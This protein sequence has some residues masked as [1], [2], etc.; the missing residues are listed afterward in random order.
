MLSQITYTDAAEIPMAMQST[1]D[2]RHDAPVRPADEREE[3]LAMIAK[4]IMARWDV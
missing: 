1:S 2:F 3:E 4:E